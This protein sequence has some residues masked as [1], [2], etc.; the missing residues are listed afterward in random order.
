MKIL[1]L[2]EELLPVE[3]ALDAEGLASLGDQTAVVEVFNR[4][5]ETHGDA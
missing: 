2:D 1:A 3:A 5:L 4:L